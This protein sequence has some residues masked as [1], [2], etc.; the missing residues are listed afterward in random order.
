MELKVLKWLVA[1]MD[2]SGPSPI[3]QTWS[4]LSF[5]SILV[6]VLAVINRLD[7]KEL[8]SEPILL[9]LSGIVGAVIGIFFIILASEKNWVFIVKHL[10]RESIEKRINEIKT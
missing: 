3:L 1:K 10:S 5:G 8:I 9:L 4:L 2:R 6:V 7:E